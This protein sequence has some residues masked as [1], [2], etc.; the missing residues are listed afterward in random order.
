M[1][2]FTILSWNGAGNQPPATAVAQALRKR[3]GVA[4]VVRTAGRR[5]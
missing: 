2:R 4:P 3:G 5:S 1:A